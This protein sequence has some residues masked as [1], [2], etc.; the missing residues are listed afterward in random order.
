MVVSTS[1]VSSSVVSRVQED[2]QTT[3]AV[4]S[5]SKG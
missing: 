4:E 3:D 2:K 5:R 1:S